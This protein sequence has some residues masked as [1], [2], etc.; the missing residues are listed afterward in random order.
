MTALPEAYSNFN[1]FPYNVAS[2]EE[3]PVIRIPS[4]I[5]FFEIC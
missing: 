3:I 2:I 4:H 5:S 1:F